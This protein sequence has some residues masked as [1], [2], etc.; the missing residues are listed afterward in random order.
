MGES[1]GFLQYGRRQVRHRPINQRIHDF[2]ETDLALSPDEIRTQAAR[3]MDCG[4]PFCHGMGCPLKNR[5]PDFNELIYKGRW[6]QACNVLHSTNNFPEVTGRVCPAPCETACT[7][8]V[9]DEPVLIRHIEFQIVE[10]G[11]EEG[12]IRPLL[13]AHKTGKCVALIGSGP[14]GLAAAQQLARAGHNV[15]VFEKDEKIGGILR[16]GIPDFKLEKSILDR[17]LE[18]LAAE[19]VDFQAGVNVGE[20]ISTRYLRRMFDCICLT[21]GAGQP[22][23]LA[24][25]GRGYENIVFAMDFLTAQNKVCSGEPINESKI[26]TAKD[27]TVIVIGGGDTGSDCVG[28]ARRQGASQIYQFEILPKPPDSRPPDTPWPMWPRIMRTSSSHEE[29]CNRRWSI[30]TKRFLGAETRLTQLE[31]CE[32]KWH[33]T[34]DSWKLKEIPESEFS[35]QADL[36]ILAMGFLHVAQDGLV[37]NLELKLDDSGNVAVDNFQ[38]SQPWVFAAGDTVS[39]ASL[40]VSAINSG[41][42]AAAAIDKWLF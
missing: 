5:I 14:A 20:D 21:V 3:C 11:F 28:T 26:I 13:P 38:T 42:Q 15:T 12:W 4:I 9:N 8:A 6:Q 1:K 41:R 22:R 17:R 19:G 16:Y 30:M 37:R 29:G 24:V 31:G 34:A 18:Q 27:K 32:V 40:V 2:N 36:V 10:R 23:D 25:Q 35:C 39:G 33:K 7:L